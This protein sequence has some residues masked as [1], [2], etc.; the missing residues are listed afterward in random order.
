VIIQARENTY[1][2]DANLAILKLFQFTPSDYNVDTTCLILLKALTNLP[3]AD[4]VLCKCLL[5]EAQVQS[6][7]IILYLLTR[8]K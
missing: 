1:D 6:N 3:H 2:L 5:T 7:F 4:F 8:L